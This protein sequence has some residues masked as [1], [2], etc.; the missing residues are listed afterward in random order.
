[1]SEIETP[2]EEGG[3]DKGTN[4]SFIV[5][6]AKKGIQAAAV[7]AADPPV[8][9]ENVPAVEDAFGEMKLTGESN[10]TATVAADDAWDT[11]TW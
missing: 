3:I 7:K 1:M 8:K 9:K 11:S 10:G 6:P 4:V 5:V 2:D